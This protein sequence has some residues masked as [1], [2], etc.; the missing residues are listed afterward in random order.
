MARMEPS[1]ARPL[2][3]TAADETPWEP[4]AQAKELRRGPPPEATRLTQESGAEP[5]ES[6]GGAPALFGPAGR[7]ARGAGPSR[8]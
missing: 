5:I 8:R 4:M 7:S 2:F 6:P 1:S 3:P